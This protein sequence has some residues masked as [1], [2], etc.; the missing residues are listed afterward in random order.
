LWL[1]DFSSAW[2]H[3]HTF[4]QEY[5]KF[6][7]VTY[8]MAGVAKWC[9][10]LHAEAVAEWREGLDCEFADAAG[11][12]KPALL[13]YFAAVLRPNVFSRAKATALLTA[14]ANDR[15]SS[16]WPGPLVKFALGKI[17]EAELRRE[18]I[19]E[20]DD[21]DTAV[22]NWESDFFVALA[23]FE[24]KNRADFVA[25]MQ[26]VASLSWQDYDANQDLFLSKIWQEEFFLARH[27][28]Q[29]KGKNAAR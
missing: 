15:R 3:F 12:A 17:A 27:E 29:V 2:E 5:P 19:Y 28:A 18:C 9:L 1:G 21:D 20:R 23:E 16:K 7:S 8:G 24:L 10:E 4:N 11:D 14:K 13:L 26:S 25:R 22:N 6:L